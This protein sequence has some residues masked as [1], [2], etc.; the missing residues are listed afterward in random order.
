MT[1]KVV[2]TTKNSHSIGAGQPESDSVFI[3][4]LVLLLWLV[5]HCT[6]LSKHQCTVD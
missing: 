2:L 6:T 4:W 3:G 5:V 1:G